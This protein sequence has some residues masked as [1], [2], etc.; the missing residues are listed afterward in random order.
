MVDWLEDFE[1]KFKGNEMIS[2]LRLV[3]FHGKLEINFCGGSPNTAHLNW[4][5][6]PY[7]SSNSVVE[8]PTSMKGG[9]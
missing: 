7:G 9:E 2:R 5:V 8:S 6:K 4:C 1:N 3:K